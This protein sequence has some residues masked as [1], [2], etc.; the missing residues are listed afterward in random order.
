MP[1]NEIIYFNNFLQKK[2]QNKKTINFT[3]FKHRNKI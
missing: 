2:K 3:T 1:K